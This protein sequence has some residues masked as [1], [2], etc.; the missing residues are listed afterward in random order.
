MKPIVIVAAVIS[1]GLAAAVALSLGEKPA[2]APSVAPVA[3]AP[4]LKTSNIYVAAQAIPV[5]TVITQEMLAVQP[6]PENL[7]LAGFIS[8]DD[9]SKN[10][11]GFVARTTFQ[12]N[13]PIIDS[14]LANPSDPNFLAGELPKGMRV[15][16]IMTTETDGVAGFVFPGDRVDVM[17]THDVEDVKADPTDPSKPQVSNNAL[18]E[19]VLTNVKVVAVDQRAA[20]AKATDEQGKLIIPRSVSLMVSP[21]DA[22]RLRLAQKVGTL[23]LALR[24]LEDRDSADSLLVT[25]MGDISQHAPGKFS[26][27]SSGSA[28]GTGGVKIYRGATEASASSADADAAQNPVAAAMSSPSTPPAMVAQ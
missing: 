5:G 23:T 7:K 19:T 2:P 15:V 8:A 20:G 11:V 13:E 17:L 6:W 1:I 24:S 16:S 10:A 27:S 12:Q 21:T 25:G 9:G 28:G 3:A 22:Q 4:E 18:T 26:A 14:K